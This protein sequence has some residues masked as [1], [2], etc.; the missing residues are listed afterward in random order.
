MPRGGPQLQFRVP[1][2][3]ESQLERLLGHPRSQSLDDLSVTAIEAL[4]KP[5]ERAQHLH[6]FAEPPWQGTVA[7]MRFLWRRRWYRA[8]DYFTQRGRTSFTVPDEVYAFVMALVV[9]MRADVVKQGP[10]SSH[11]RSR[12]EFVPV[13]VASNRATGL[14]SCAA[15]S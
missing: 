6:D 2:G 1:L 10:N 12:A 11:S 5:Y 14:T 8:G 4:G 15:W 3:P 13:P 9:D 7:L